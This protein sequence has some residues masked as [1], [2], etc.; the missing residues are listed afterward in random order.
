[1]TDHSGNPD[2]LYVLWTSGDREVALKMVFM[3]ARN[4]KV[5]GWWEEVALIVWGPSAALLSRDDELRREVAEMREAGVELLAC[6]ACSDA[7]GVTEKLEAQ[8]VS[9]IYMGE[10][11][12]DLL[13]RGARLVTF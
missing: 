13:K 4:A 10:P 5:R 1:M 9:V 3:Y 2:K 7:Y 8:G 6:R 12:T 11:L